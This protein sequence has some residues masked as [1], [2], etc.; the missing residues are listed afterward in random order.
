MKLLNKNSLILHVSFLRNNILCT[1]TN[2]RGGTLL[3]VSGGIERVKGLKK[4]SNSLVFSIVKMLFNF[5]KKLNR[6]NLYIKIKGINKNK[7]TF[8]KYLQVLG[9]N[10]LLIQE[11]FFLPHGGCKKP[12]SRKL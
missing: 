6:F 10:I 3:Q 9:F 11:K 4:N 1:L 5:C 2:L 8:I 12:K 7:P